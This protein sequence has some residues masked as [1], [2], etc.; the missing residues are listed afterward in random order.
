MR[1]DAS[2]YHRNDEAVIGE[3]V[4]LSIDCRETLVGRRVVDAD[5]ESVRLAVEVELPHIFNERV[6]QPMG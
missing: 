4:A 6:R 3:R 2:W 5:D 1:V